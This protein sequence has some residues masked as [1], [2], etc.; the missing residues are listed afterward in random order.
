MTLTQEELEE[1]G[2]RVE[3]S[4]RVFSAALPPIFGWPGRDWNG[5]ALAVEEQRGARVAWFGEMERS[6]SLHFAAQ[7]AHEWLSERAWSTDEKAEWLNRRRRLVRGGS[8]PTGAHNSGR[9]GSTPASVT[10]KV[11]VARFDHPEA[12]NAWPDEVET[13]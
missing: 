1:F 11:E 12:W 6:G 2:A 5:R 10:I 13:A 8:E 4:L 9:A 7:A 3:R